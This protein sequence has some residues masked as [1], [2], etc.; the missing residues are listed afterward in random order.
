MC[1][2][3]LFQSSF[4]GFIGQVAGSLHGI[5]AG[6]SFGDGISKEAAGQMLSQKSGWGENSAS[7]C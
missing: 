1:A 5:F 2:G 6:A 4:R 7:K 3:G